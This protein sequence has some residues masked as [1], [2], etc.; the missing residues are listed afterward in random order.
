[1]R[2]YRVALRMRLTGVCRFGLERCICALRVGRFVTCRFVALASNI[3][4]CLHRLVCSR[5]SRHRSRHSLA[6]V[7]RPDLHVVSGRGCGLALSLVMSDYTL[8]LEATTANTPDKA[9]P[10]DTDKG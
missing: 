8:P 3:R 10:V 6:P 1:M 9:Q 7:F 2:W 5:C 4:V